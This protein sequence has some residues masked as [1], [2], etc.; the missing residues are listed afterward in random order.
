MLSLLPMSQ[1]CLRL[2]RERTEPT[3]SESLYSF[4]Q[5]TVLMA[6]CYGLLIN[7]AIQIPFSLPKLT[8]GSSQFTKAQTQ[9]RIDVA[10]RWQPREGRGC[11]PDKPRTWSVNQLPSIC[12]V[13]AFRADQDSSFFCLL[14]HCFPFFHA[15]S[16][17]LWKSAGPL[18]SCTLC[19]EQQ[20]IEQAM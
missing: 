20:S 18:D 5:I 7:F 2:T 3:D 12:P 19:K 15:S 14:L 1:R 8:D 6:F 16:A 9:D 13:E 10:G 4:Q 11:H 17:Q